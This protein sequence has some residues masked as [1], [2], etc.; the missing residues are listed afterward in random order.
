MV[1][2]IVE[3]RWK[4]EDEEKVFSVV[5]SI[6]EMSKSGKLPEG[7][8]LGSVNVIGEERRAICNWE[9]PGVSELEGLVREVSP[10]TE[11]RVFEAKRIL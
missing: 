10:P 4:P 1:N 2:A 7:F 6:I 5:G 3:H 11:F 9:A 8:K